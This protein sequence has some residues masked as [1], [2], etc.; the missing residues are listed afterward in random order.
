MNDVSEKEGMG[1]RARF[2]DSEKDVRGKINIP[3]AMAIITVEQRDRKM[4]SVI[5]FLVFIVLFS[6]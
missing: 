6:I 1:D 2:S 5:R 3:I 4:M